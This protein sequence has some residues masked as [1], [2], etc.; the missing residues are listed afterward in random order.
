MSFSMSCTYYLIPRAFLRPASCCFPSFVYHTRDRYSNPYLLKLTDT[1]RQVARCTPVH[2]THVVRNLKSGMHA[3]QFGASSTANLLDIRTTLFYTIL[4]RR[5]SFSDRYTLFIMSFFF[6]TNSFFGDYRHT[7][8]AL[9]FRDKFVITA[10]KRTP[11]CSLREFWCVPQQCRPLYW[12]IGLSTKSL[13]LG[14]IDRPQPAVYAFGS[15]VS[16]KC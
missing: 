12:L 5:S 4:L 3:T 8:H 9:M 14:S 15:V 6:W 7:N 16:I 13:S 10:Q 2:R 11:R 1:C